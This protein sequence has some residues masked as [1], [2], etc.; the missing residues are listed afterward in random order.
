MKNTR[1]VISIAPNH[2]EKGIAKYGGIL[3]GQLASLI[4]SAGLQY[5]PYIFGDGRI[6]LVLPNNLGGFLYSDKEAMFEALSL[7]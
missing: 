3:D 6:L 5:T 2:I 1:G 4:K 7:T